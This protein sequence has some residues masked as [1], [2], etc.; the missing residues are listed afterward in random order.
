M[1]TKL[2]LGRN[3]SGG[4]GIAGQMTLMELLGMER[5]QHQTR[6]ELE[7]LRL[8]GR[9]APPHLARGPAPT[10]LQQD[11]PIRCGAAG[12][13]YISPQQLRP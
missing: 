11:S 8:E 10:H 1:M 3:L 7:T 4:G 5:L 12:Q 6:C 2:F 13:S 9:A